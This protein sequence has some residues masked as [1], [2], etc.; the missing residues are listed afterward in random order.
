MSDA[1]INHQNKKGTVREFT[2]HDSPPQNGVSERG[3]RTRAEM[4]RAL[5]I[6]SGLPRFLWEEAMKHGNWIQNR[7]PTRALDGK[8]PYE[9][10]TK[11]KPNLAGIQEFGATAYV[12]DLKA[13]K[14]DS[15][16]KL[17]RF[18][19]YDSESKGYR[20]Y[21]PEKR[22]ITVER[23]VVFNQ[24]DTQ[25]QNNTAIIH[26]ETLSEG[27]K[28]KIIQLPQNKAENPEK[29]EENISED[30]EIHEKEPESHLN[31]SSSSSIP[32]PTSEEEPEE[33]P[34]EPDEESPADDTS[35]YG[36]GK[37]DRPEKGSYKIMNRRGLTAVVATLDDEPKANSSVKRPEE[38]DLYPPELALVGHFPD[39]PKT[40][41]EALKGPNTKEWEE[42]LK[43]EI[44][45]LEK[46]GTWEVV[47]LPRGKTTIPCSEVIKVK[48]GPNGEVQTYRVRIV[49]GGHRQVEGVNYTETFSA[50]AKMPTVRTVLANAAHQNWE[51]EHI[52]VKSAYLNAPLKEEIYMKPPRGVLKPGQEGKVLRLLK[53]LYGLK[54]AGRGWYMEMSRIFM[55]DLGFKRSGIDH[56]VFYRRDGEEHTIV[57]VATDDMAVT[58]K[59]KVDADKFKT[60]VKKFWDITDHGPIKW[61][62]GFE[63][64][65]DR[66]AR[67]I[68]INQHAYIESM[69]Q[70]FRLT[71]AKPVTTPLESNAKF[72]KEQSP[73]S[74]TQETRMNGVPYQEAIG[75]ILWAAVVSRPDVAYAVGI[76]S[77][78]MQKPGQAHWEGVKRVIN[79]LGCT[80]DLWLTFGGTKSVM[81]EGY[82]DADWASQEGRHSISGFSFHFGVGAI[83]WSSKKQ[84]II[85]LSTTEAEY[86]SQTHAAKEAI[87][88]QTFVSEINGGTIQTLTVMGDNQGAIALAKD[89]KFHSRTKHIDLRY[90][91]VREAVEQGKI[92]MKYLPS[93]DN[94]ADVFTKP[95]AKQQFQRLVGL[96]GLG[97]L[98]P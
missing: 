42:A 37:R 66:A 14:L 64:K 88:L 76:L 49:A 43:Y 46:L 8:T 17:G 23:D 51:I 41:D 94:V 24:D 13:G 16:A 27:E 18:V 92:S 85:A 79:Y 52:D 67:T 6:S 38:P 15:R 28:E 25:V 22:S 58:S 57:A 11:K 44:N 2:V 39:D 35:E 71:N 87:W 29:R 53:G 83:S 40:L 1:L 26:G 19:G 20:I 33:Q 74:T 93:S 3:M 77:Q 50:A 78:F 54:Q 9:M 63:I 82:C 81:L 90:H 86:I 48:R 59:R 89:N 10:K 45:Q 62:L 36:R 65:R 12:K 32:F 68:S 80:K 69:V 72:S 30:Q 91:F 61:F 73:S 95:L 97:M 21:W 98:K 5:L 75:S 7:S 60:N 96:L 70:K 55:K 31:P 34:E 84:P 56:S 4:A 47:N